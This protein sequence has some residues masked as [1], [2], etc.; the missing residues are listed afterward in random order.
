MSTSSG[1]SFKDKF[2]IPV[3]IGISI[4]IITAIVVGEG[5]FATLIGAAAQPTAAP[6]APPATHESSAESE[7][8]PEAAPTAAAPPT[9]VP[10]TPTAVERN[11]TALL[12]ISA[13]S[14]L[15]DE[16]IPG[17]GLVR[18]IPEN[19]ID[20]NPT[21]SW[22]EGIEGPGIGE[23]LSLDFSQPVTLTRLGIRV[24]FDRDD[25]I[26]LKNYR[27]H[28]ARLLF[29]DGSSQSVEFEDRRGIQY[30]S[31]AHVRTT[32]LIIVIDEVYQSGRYD[33]TPIAEVEIW[34]YKSP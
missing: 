22:V 26:F 28:H 24:G 8:T 7:A 23:R 15:P 32:S 4:S 10:P 29:S 20:G 1:Q 11:L 17:L 5:R 2:V 14:V 6:A 27:L 19:A 12:R 16:E 33:D 31:I 30:V 21:T 18:Y 13:S 25:D 9:P 3:C 34:G